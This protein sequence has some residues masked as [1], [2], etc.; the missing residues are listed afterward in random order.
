MIGTRTYKPRV[1]IQARD[2]KMLN[3]LDLLRVATGNQLAILCGFTSTTRINARLHQL[4]AAKYIHRE[5]IGTIAGGR[6]A[7]YMLPRKR[8]RARNGPAGL[9][10]AVQHQ[11]AV[12]RVYLALD[13]EVT[14]TQLAIAWRPPSRATTE[15]KLIPDAEITLGALPNA[16]LCFLEVDYGTE[17]SKVWRSKVG[18]YLD[19][20]ADAEAL[21]RLAVERFRVLVIATTDAALRRIR[22]TV[23]ET[24]DKVFW[25]TTIQSITEAGFLAPIW[26]RPKGDE[27]HAL[28]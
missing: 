1:I 15:S 9:E 7:V 16:R 10:A 22:A 18:R 12:N 23:A 28:I 14:A 4:V 24:T 11:L 27:K 8:V 5:F 6:L 13:R 21:R 17:G 19:L 20:A 2:R 3:L 26:L 25:L